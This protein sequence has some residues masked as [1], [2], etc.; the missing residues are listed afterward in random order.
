MEFSKTSDRTGLIQLLEDLTNT[1]SA[2]SSSYTLAT[3]T[4]D[5][6]NAY[7]KYFMIALQASG[8]WQVD[9]TNQTDYPIMT[10]DLIASQQDYAFTVDQNLNQV[11][12]IYRVEIADASGTWQVI[13]PYDE[14]QE[15]TSL[16]EQA[17]ESGTP[18]RY[19]KTAN[20]I[21]LDRK[22]SYN[23]TNGLKIYFA[24]SPSYFASTDTTKK[25]GIP[26]M[27]HEYLAMRPAYYYS[28]AKGLKQA[29]NFKVEVLEMEKSIMTYHSLRTRDEK[30]RLVS[31]RESTR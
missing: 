16:T 3:K 31:R 7:A 30:P 26:D 6:N 11:W 1:Q 29:N 8:T 20:G 2:S 18:V 22:P 25:P 28:L 5:I 23:S 14:N 19:S 15:E 9:D 4:R 10:T 17:T 21:F 12:D 27:F 24:R 13:D